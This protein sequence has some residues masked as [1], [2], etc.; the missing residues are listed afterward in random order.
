MQPFFTH[1][2]FLV[3]IDKEDIGKKYLDKWFMYCL[4]I[5]LRN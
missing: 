5:Y 2:L 4:V 3:Q 1:I